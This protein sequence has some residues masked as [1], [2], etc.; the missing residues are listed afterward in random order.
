MPLA[1]T[2]NGTPVAP[3]AEAV[4]RGDYPF[5]RTLTFVLPRPPTGDT[6]RFIDWVL[7]DE[8][9]ALVLA[10]GFFPVR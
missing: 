6:R 9:Q 7:S 4:R 5:S 2:V 3:T 10:A 1:V 8:G